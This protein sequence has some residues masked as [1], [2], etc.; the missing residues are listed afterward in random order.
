MTT[1]TSLFVFDYIRMTRKPIYSHALA[2][3]NPANSE[4]YVLQVPKSI[5]KPEMEPQGQ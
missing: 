1:L 4:T 2:R 5:S 3:G